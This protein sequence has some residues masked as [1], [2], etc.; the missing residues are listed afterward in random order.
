MVQIHSPRLLIIKVLE[1]FYEHLSDELVVLNLATDLAGD[2]TS[3]LFV[4]GRSRFQP[5]P[6]EHL[7]EVG[8][9]GDVRLGQ[10]LSVA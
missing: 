8:I 7:I 9:K 6:S 3:G 1:D 2:L 5:H 10:V 4:G